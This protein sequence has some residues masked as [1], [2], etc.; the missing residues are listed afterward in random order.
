MHGT[1]E[2]R[3]QL[4]FV[5][6]LPMLG[7]FV[8]AKIFLPALYHDIVQEDAFL[9]NLQ[10]VF[11]ALAAAFALAAAAV[12][13]RSR[14]RSL[15]L[16]HLGLSGALIFVFFEEVSWGQRLLGIESFEFFKRHNRQGEITI[17]NLA[18]VHRNLH[19][20]YI[21][22]GLYGG[23]A[24]LSVRTKA[25]DRFDWRRFCFAPWYCSFY[26]LPVAGIYML[27]H[28]V[29]PLLDTLF[30]LPEFRV[31]SFFIWRDQE[32]GE[33]LLSLGFLLLAVGNFAKARTALSAITGR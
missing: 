5:L 6:P 18:P 1:H 26:F 15:A 12:L 4:L 31:G 16:L 8:Y 29:C 27:L 10:P 7:L 22:V 21:L 23:L 14:Q 25:L 17:H 24:W 33:T 28:G 20:A 30:G 32:P 19:L 11:Y 2:L 13:Q 3:N 9:E